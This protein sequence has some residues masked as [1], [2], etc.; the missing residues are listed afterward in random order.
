VYARAREQ[1]LGL[2]LPLGLWKTRD[3]G[4]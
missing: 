2:A 1:G 3:G 4:S